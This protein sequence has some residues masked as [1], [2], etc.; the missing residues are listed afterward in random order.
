[1]TV[2]EFVD[3]DPLD[4]RSLA[5]PA[6]ARRVARLVAA[7]H[8]ATPE[9]AVPVP[10][11]ERFEVAGD[12]LR[13][14]LAALDPG[15][16]IAGGLVAEARALVWPQRGALLARLERVMALGATIAGAGSGEWVL[17]HRDLI[18]DNLL[19]DRGGRLWLVD[20]DSAALA[21]PRSR[22]G[23]VHRPRL[24]AVSG[25]LRGRRRALQPRPGP[26]RLLPAAPQPRRSG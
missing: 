4:D 3:G 8:A 21:P 14:R 5:D 11:V 19:V 15:T 12:D 10:F 2:F 18:V 16:G 17:C 7:I 9:L 22:P 20:W 13:R 24:P 26:G 25:R 23:P 6:T 1:V